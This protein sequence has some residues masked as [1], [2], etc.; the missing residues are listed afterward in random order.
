[1]QHFIRSYNRHGHRRQSPQHSGLQTAEHAQTHHFQ[2]AFLLIHRRLD[3][4]HN[5]WPG[6]ICGIRLQIRSTRNPRVLL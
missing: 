5:V 4:T 3:N 1:M 2:A 6:D